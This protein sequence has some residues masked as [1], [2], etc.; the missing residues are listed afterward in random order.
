MKRRVLIYRRFERFWH[1]A[2]ALLVVL[3]ALTGFDVHFG[4]GLFRFDQA[5]TLHKVFAWCFV[6]LIAFA[7]FWHLTTGEWRQYKPG[8]NLFAMVRYYSLGIFLNEPHPVKKTRLTKLNPLQKIAYLALKILVIPVTVTSGFLYYYYNRWDHIG[9]DGWR[10]GSIAALHT[11]AA[12]A[13][14]GGMI[15][16]IYLS[17]TGHTASSNIKA[18]ITGHE[19]LDDDAE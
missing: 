13:I 9:I 19:L 2:Q 4:W 1:W 18:M 17:T 11:L 14:V 7:I 12:F 5:V 10:L 15:A 16:H 3:L 6:G 8:G